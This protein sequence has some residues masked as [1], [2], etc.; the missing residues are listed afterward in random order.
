MS[1]SGYCW[2][3]DER[4]GWDDSDADHTACMPGSPA[5]CDCDCHGWDDRDYELVTEELAVEQ[6]AQRTAL[7]ATG[8]RDTATCEKRQVDQ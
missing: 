4:D 6:E 5:E 2:T 1:V 7:T 3:G 8:A